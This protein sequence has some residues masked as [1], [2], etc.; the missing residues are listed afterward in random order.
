MKP[1][2]LLVDDDPLLLAGLKRQLRRHFHILTATGGLEALQMVEAQ[3]DPLM[4]VVRIT[5]CRG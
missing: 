3:A 5:G 2:I 1:R 4:V